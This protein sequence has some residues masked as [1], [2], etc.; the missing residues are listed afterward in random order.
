M[1]KLTLLLC[2]AGVALFSSFAQAAPLP[3]SPLYYCPPIDGLN[4]TLQQKGPSHIQEYPVNGIQY[5]YWSLGH[6]IAQS[7]KFGGPELTSIPTV[8]NG[9]ARKILC[10]YYLTTKKGATFQVF[11]SAADAGPFVAK[12][13]NWDKVG[14]G[15]QGT[16]CTFVRANN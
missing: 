4:I 8:G 9:A 1:K 3:L 13:G 7:D 11:Y 10:T 14:G 12:G 5:K 15:C 16:D 2:A 6:S